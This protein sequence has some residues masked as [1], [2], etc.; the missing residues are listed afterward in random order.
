M[1]QLVSYADIAPPVENASCTGTATG[2]NGHISKKNKL[3]NDT[4]SDTT[5]STEETTPMRS[6][7]KFE[8][9]RELTHEEIWDDSALI[10]AWNAATEEYEALNGPDK[11]WKSDPVHKSPLYVLASQCTA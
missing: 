1:R 10:E 11:G 7:V 3:R 6:R 2:S 5:T 4:E 9:S 8:E